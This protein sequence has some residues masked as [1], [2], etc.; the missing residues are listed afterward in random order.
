[1]INWKVRFRNKRFILA[2]ASALLL[3]VQVVAKV[4]GIQINVS[5]LNENSVELINA[6]CGVLTILGVVT[7]PTTEGL[8]DS[9]R[10]LGYEKPAG[11][12]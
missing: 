9:E 7:D 11:G 1:M 10:A 3:V 12:K 8:G 5:A 2:L 6:V 4:F